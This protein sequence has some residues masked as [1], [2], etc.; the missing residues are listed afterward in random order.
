MTKAITNIIAGS[1]VPLADKSHQL[2]S[3]NRVTSEEHIY[4][5]V[6]PV[7][8]DPKQS[9][10]KNKANPCYANQ[11][12]IAAASRPHVYEY[13]DLHLRGPAYMNLPGVASSN[14]ESARGELGN[15]SP[16]EEPRP[17]LPAEEPEP[18]SQNEKAG[19]DPCSCLGLG[20][21][22]ILL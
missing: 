2:D 3:E 17:T 10:P 16:P 21:I 18:T 11:S 14:K 20:P 1:F 4:A 19:S 8:T 6:S 9:G 12:E 22:I 5:A 15:A 7:G 13:L